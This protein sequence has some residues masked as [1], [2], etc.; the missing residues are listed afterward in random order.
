V[1]DALEPSD[2][3]ATVTTVISRD[4]RDIVEAHGYVANASDFGDVANS[5]VRE[6]G[7]ARSGTY[8]Y[9]GETTRDPAA[10]PVTPPW[11]DADPIAT[12]A[13]L[14]SPA[15]Q[16]WVP[17]L[18][19]LTQARD[20]AVAAKRQAA[21]VKRSQRAS[22]AQQRTDHMLR[23]EQVRAE[24]QRARVGLPINH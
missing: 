3:P 9:D 24:V 1:Q 23:T 19:Q 4:V 20:A 13:F 5:R 10:L 15:A 21:D 11:L 16:P 22:A 8:L 6:E 7:G 2:N 12:L 17:T 14:A 18:R